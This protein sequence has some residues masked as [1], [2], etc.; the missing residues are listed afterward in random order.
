MTFPISKANGAPCLAAFP[1][2]ELGENVG[3]VFFHRTL[4][5]VPLHAVHGWVARTYGEDEVS[6]LAGLP[7][8]VIAA[9]YPDA[10]AEGVAS[11]S[12]IRESPALDQLQEFLD[13]VSTKI[14]SH[15]KWFLAEIHLVHLWESRNRFNFHRSETAE[16]EWMKA[17][18]EAAEFWSDLKWAISRTLYV[19]PLADDYSRAEFRAEYSGVVYLMAMFLCA[20]YLN[21]SALRNVYDEFGVNL[22]NVFRSLGLDE[23][24]ERARDAH[25]RQSN[26]SY[27]DDDE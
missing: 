13:A 12:L 9:L 19:D 7:I 3:G 15:D 27:G 1:T 24:V 26:L 4:D 25:V 6:K 10:M 23:L 18:P 17:V 20:P 11:F 14:D 22:A 8:P 16:K 2:I 5:N 21:S